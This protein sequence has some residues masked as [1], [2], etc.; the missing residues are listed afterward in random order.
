M[1]CRLDTEFS[2]TELEL[3]THVV[4]F[5]RVLTMVYCT[6][7]AP[8]FWTLPILSFTTDARTT[9]RSR[10]CS[11]LKWQGSSGNSLSY[12]YCQRVFDVSRSQWPRG[13]RRRSAAVRLLRLWL[14]I[15]PR[16]WMPVCW[17][18]S[19][20]GLCDGLITRPEESY[21][22][23]RVVVCDHETS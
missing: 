3:Q 14:R 15:P 11:I 17:V 10:F 22:L 23:W 4:Q 21:R 20:R 13:L 8:Y 2:S 18:L 19:D 5:Y 6:R 1:V 16:A 9:L 7:A 12:I